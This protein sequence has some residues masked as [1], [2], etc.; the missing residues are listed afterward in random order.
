M[1]KRTKIVRLNEG[2]RFS[3]LGPHPKAPSKKAYRAD[4]DALQLKLLRIQ[5]HYHHSGGRAVILFQG[6]DAGG[7]GGAIRRITGKLDPRGFR[8][9]AIA[10]PTPEEQG[11]HY[12]WRFWQRLPQ[13]GRFAI[14]DRSWYGRVL[15]ERI[16]GFA[17][18]SE[19]K[20]A[21][22]EINEFEHTLIDDGV[23]I[24][25]LFLHITA[26]EQLRRFEQ[27]LND[28]YKRWKLTSDDLRNREKWNDYEAALEDMLDKTSTKAAPWTLILA[29]HKWYA[30]LA[31]LRRVVEVL[32]EG[33]DLTVPVID[34]AV[35]EEARRRLGLAMERSG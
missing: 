20:R 2:T 33:L 4:L 10:A 34:D 24:V 3:Q 27:R 15:V 6:W 11:R 8:V 29:N 31:V 9:H 1:S 7:K 16:E 30:R 18:K 23:R 26:D 35:I 25:K 14:F 12:L 32:G 5:Q 13:P 21:Y 28:P 19:W 22:D 17:T